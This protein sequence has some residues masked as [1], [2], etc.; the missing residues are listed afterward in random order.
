L[1]G[2]PLRAFGR[3]DVGEAFENRHR[4]AAGLGEAAVVQR[5]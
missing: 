2:V 4:R 1:R 5:V 3:F